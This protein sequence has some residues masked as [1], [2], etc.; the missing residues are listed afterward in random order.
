VL[1]WLGAELVGVSLS[2]PRLLE[3]GVNCLPVA[4][5]FLGVAGLA[6]A[7]I[8]RAS[9][10]IAYGVVAVAFLWQLFGSLVGAPKWLVDITPFAH[11]AAVPAQSFRVG[12]AAV[13]V[14]AGVLAGLIAIAT[15]ERRDLLGS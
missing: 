6:Y 12:A 2:F 11:V 3:A 5:L 9:T 7:A 8:P 13:M 15:F 1:A 4:L 10:G 14:G